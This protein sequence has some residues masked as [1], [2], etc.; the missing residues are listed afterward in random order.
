MI[1]TKDTVK[2]SDYFCHLP[3]HLEMPRDSKNLMVGKSYKFRTIVQG[4][5][6]SVYLVVDSM[7]N[8]VPANKQDSDTYPYVITPKKQGKFYIQIIFPDK[9]G[10]FMLDKPRLLFTFSVEDSITNGVKK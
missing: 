7:Y 8:L 6:P 4:I 5:D 1:I 3:T 9:N 10:Y 2:W